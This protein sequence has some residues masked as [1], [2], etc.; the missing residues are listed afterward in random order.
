MP[1]PSKGAS[2]QSNQRALEADDEQLHDA[3]GVLSM[4]EAASVPPLE[5]LDPDVMNDFLE[6]LNDVLGSWARGEPGD[7]KDLSTCVL[8]AQIPAYAALGR[9]YK[10]LHEAEE[11]E[12]RDDP[13]VEKLLNAAQL[14]VDAA[15]CMNEAARLRTLG[16]SR[17]PDGAG[18]PPV[19]TRTTSA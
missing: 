3:L 14:L 19:D 9:L 18:I 5:C 11:L 7:P 16:G 15:A 17:P 6:M 1:P 12:E 13:W 10:V 2:M 4:V 8:A